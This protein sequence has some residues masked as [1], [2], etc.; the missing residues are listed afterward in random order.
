MNGA[1]TVGNVPDDADAPRSRDH[2]EDEATAHIWARLTITLATAAGKAVKSMKR[3]TYTVVA[4]PWIHPQ[5]PR[6]RAR[7]QPPDDAARVRRHADVEGEARADG[8]APLP[9]RP[10][11]ADDEGLRED[12]ALERHTRRLESATG[13]SVARRSLKAAAARPLV[14]SQ[15]DRPASR[16]TG[17][18][19]RAFSVSES[20]G[21][22][23]S[24]PVIPSAS[25]RSKHAAPSAATRR[26][27]ARPT[28]G[29]AARSRPSRGSG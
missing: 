15:T 19:V 24:D 6:R 28:H 12:R 14:A 13:I 7:L 10:A 3:G 21:R 25:M 22:I 29:S 11:C 18:C 2:A 1:F 17:P 27:P 23:V 16:Q 20:P 26:S 5:R 4:R 9:L 8:D